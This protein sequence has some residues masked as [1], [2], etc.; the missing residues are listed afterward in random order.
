MALLVPHTFNE[1]SIRYLI[2]L[3]DVYA[4]DNSTIATVLG[5]TRQN[6]ATFEPEDDDVWLPVS[7][8]MKTGKL[9]RLRISYRATVSGRTR[10]KSARII[11]PRSKVNT[12]I[13]GLK[14]KTYQG[15]NITGAGIPRRRRRT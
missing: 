7:E 10:T 11:C 5:L 9:V 4:S 15:N 2:D 12:A 3:P 1:E 14:G 8:G 13:S 6:P